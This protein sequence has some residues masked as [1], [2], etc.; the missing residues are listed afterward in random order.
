[1]NFVNIN[2]DVDYWTDLEGFESWASELNNLFLKIIEKKHCNF[3]K[4]YVNLLLTN[5]ENIRKLN[6]DFRDKD[7]STNVLSFPQYDLED[8]CKI[9]TM[10]SNDEVLLGDIAMSHEKI[11]RESK[12]FDFKFFDRCSHLFV[13]GVLHL[14]GMDHMD[15]KSEAEMENLE[16]EILDE[17][18]IENPYILK[19][20]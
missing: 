15:S 16:I 19:G 2:K 5:D 1:M 20:E 12:E 14:F 11:M 9:D 10:I 4:F 18:G 8:I 13:H 3:K 17:V 6:R 7:S